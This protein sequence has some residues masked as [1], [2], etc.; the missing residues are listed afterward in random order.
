MT[1]N[2][3]LNAPQGI[4]TEEMAFVAAREGME[5]EFVRAE[6]SLNNVDGSHCCANGVGGL[7]FLHHRVSP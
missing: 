4:I 3:P 7:G 6:V 2:A 1:T 5:P